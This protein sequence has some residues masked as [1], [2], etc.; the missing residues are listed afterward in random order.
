MK[1][2]DVVGQN[3]FVL[4]SSK[5]KQVYIDCLEIIIDTCDAELSY[6]I[7]REYI[8][9]KLIP[10]FDLIG[11]A[12]IQF[13][14]DEEIL[15]D[16][17]SKAYSVLRCLV[18]Y[19]WIEIDSDYKQ[20]TVSVLDHSVTLLKTFRS[21]A[22]QEET[23]YRTEISQIYASLMN[24]ELRKQPYSLVLEPV[25]QRTDD[26]IMGLKKLNTSIKKYVN[27]MSEK[28]NFNDIMGNLSLYIHSNV[29]DAFDR[30]VA[31]ENIS[32]FRLKIKENLRE[33]RTDKELFEKAVAE[34]VEQ[35]KVDENT[36]REDLQDLILRVL[37]VFDS[38]DTLIEEIQKKNTRYVQ[39][40]VDRVKFLNLN[41]ND[42]ES[43]ISV[44]LQEMQKN[45]EGK[46]KEEYSAF[47][48]DELSSMFNLYPQNFFNND[49]LYTTPMNKGH[50][51]L[52]EVLPDSVMSEEEK[53]KKKV[54]A[55]AMIDSD[56]DV[57]KVNDYILSQIGEKDEVKVSEINVR[58]KKEFMKILYALVFEKTPT[59]KYKIAFTDTVIH[60][61]GWNFRDFLL[62]KKKEKNKK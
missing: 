48:S 43:K 37:S 41:T 50:V 42:V 44:I 25:S 12:D 55:K 57:K 52:E 61:F 24:P 7:N 29:S 36:A 6:S 58:E 9:E 5:H 62:Q 38:Y 13:D 2:F 56:F 4:L 45:L 47:I 8:I 10:Y 35:K 60:K 26:L 32:K 1:L 14:D 53:L 28:T 46:N 22:A 23:E 17:R 30:L 3:F 33:F 31:K 19:G 27:Q 51:E 54:A 49:S 15:R 39:S 40:A 34:Y 18:R 11:Q 21:I 20:T 59:A 16:S